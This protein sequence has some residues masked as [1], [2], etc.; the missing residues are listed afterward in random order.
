MLSWC[1][2]VIEHEKSVP[3]KSTLPIRTRYV[4]YYQVMKSIQFQTACSSTFDHVDYAKLKTTY[5]IST[6]IR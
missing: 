1:V 5:A 4:Y 2:H 6:R 3:G